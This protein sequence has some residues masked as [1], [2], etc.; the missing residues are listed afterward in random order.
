M[1][2]AEQ[3]ASVLPHLALIGG[4]WVEGGGGTFEV[5]S[6]YSGE[7]VNEITRCSPSDVDRAVAAATAAQPGWAATPLIDRV[8]VLRRINALFVERAEPIARVL[9]QEIGKTI[10]ESREEVH[11][12]AAPS[13]HKAGEEVLRHRGLS[14]PSTQEQT[15]NKRLV[16]THRPLGVVGAIT[17]YNFPTDIA[18]IALAHIVAAGNTVVWKPSEFAATACAMVGE[19]FAEAGLPDGVINVVQGLGDVGAAIVEHPGVKGVFFTGSTA[20]GKTIA[21]KAALKPHLLELGGD[22][23]F[24]ILPDAAIDAA[25]E[26][27]RGGDRD[28]QL[29]RARADRLAVDPGSG[30]GVAGRRGSPARVGEHQRDQQ[31]L[32][33]TGAVRRHGQQRRGAGALAMVPRV[34]HRAEAA[35]LRSGGRPAP[36]SASR[37]RLVEGF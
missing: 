4:R 20:T 11:E 9:V 7:L 10:T 34:L 12:Y 35:R 22:G 32:G 13:W 21:V 28:R 3:T 19:F 16:L 23:P 17:P 2:I 30:V 26:G 33:P 29:E 8:K 27:D 6:P 18:S 36:R 1:V 24:I 31:L 14:F 25:V 5:R 37:G 15:N